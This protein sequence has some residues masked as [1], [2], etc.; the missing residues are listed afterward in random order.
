MKELR[1]LNDLTIQAQRALGS[2]GW[3]DQRRRAWST[4]TARSSYLRLI[5]SCIT[6]LTAQGPSRTCNVSKKEEEE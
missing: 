6:L 5:D 3:E 4:S 1:D 2:T